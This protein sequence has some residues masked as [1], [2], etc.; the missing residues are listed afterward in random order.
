MLI[1][2]RL[3]QM[4]ERVMKNC[5]VI[6]FCK[7]LDWSEY[8]RCAPRRKK[9][10]RPTGSDSKDANG[11]EQSFVCPKCPS[12]FTYERGLQQHLKYACYQKPRF[13]CPYCHYRSKWRYNAYNH[14]RHSHPG[15]EVY[16]IDVID[17]I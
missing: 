7:H 13:Q 6:F 15:F 12:K 10:G 4:K 3:K 14:I 17:N 1:D 16:C 2:D 9:R 5:F 8:I 11:E